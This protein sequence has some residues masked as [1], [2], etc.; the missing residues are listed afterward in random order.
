MTKERRK[1]T[2]NL[3]RGAKGKK[4]Q[5][6]VDVLKQ[7]GRNVDQQL[8][9]K[10]ERGVMTPTIATAIDLAVAYEV[11]FIEIVEALGFEPEL[12]RLQAQID[13]SKIL[14]A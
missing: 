2:L 12:D 4:Q 3:L 1:V 11:S 5:D 13:K 6:I 9:S 7:L 8:V 14:Q 10:W